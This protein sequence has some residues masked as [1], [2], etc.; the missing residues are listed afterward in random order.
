MISVEQLRR[1]PFFAGFSADQIE[2]LANISEEH[3]VDAEHYFF[4]E[5]DE[6]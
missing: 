1:Y 3:S 6:K 5:G 4:Y 2:R